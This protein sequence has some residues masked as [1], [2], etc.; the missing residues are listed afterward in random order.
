MVA[1]GATEADMTAG[2]MEGES[3]VAERTA[4]SMVKRSIHL[5]LL[6]NERTAWRSTACTYRHQNLN[7]TVRKH[8]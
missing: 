7:S 6:H 1:T 8:I 5:L 4:C 2:A 3:G